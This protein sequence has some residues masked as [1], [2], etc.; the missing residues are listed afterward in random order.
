MDRHIYS[1]HTRDYLPYSVASFNLDLNAMHIT[2]AY[3]TKEDGSSNQNCHAKPSSLKA[4]DIA[5]KKQK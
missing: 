5:Y 4:K 3:F 1:S 2:F